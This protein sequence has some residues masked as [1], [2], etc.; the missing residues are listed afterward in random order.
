MEPVTLGQG[1]PYDRTAAIS[2]LLGYFPSTASPKLNYGKQ[3]FFTTRSEISVGIVIWLMHLGTAEFSGTNSWDLESALF[4]K[5]LAIFFKKKSVLWAM[6]SWMC[7]L[8]IMKHPL[9]ISEK[10]ESKNVLWHLLDA[11]CCCDISS[12]VWVCV[13]LLGY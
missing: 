9:L 10:E 4:F 13:Y 12:V 8:L 3:Q 6:I 11:S 7:L 5:E 1:H 2:N